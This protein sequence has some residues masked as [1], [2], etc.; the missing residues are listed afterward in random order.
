MNNLRGLYAITDNRLTPA[1]SILE[2]VKEALAG[3]ARI[4]QLRDKFSSDDQLIDLAKELRRLCHR[5]GAIFLINDRVELARLVKADGVHLGKDDAA[6]EEA[7]QVLGKEVIIG[8]SCYNEFERA[9]A[10]AEA[11]ADYVA[12]G[13]FFPS[14]TKPDAVRAN[15]ELLKKAKANINVPIC[16]IG[17]ITSSNA[18]ELIEAGADMIAVISDLWKAPDVRLKAKQFSSIFGP[19]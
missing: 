8:I 14:P 7:R 2:M 6:Y 1:G 17:G 4:I 3:G 9:I 12:F 16:A 5:Y 15:K 10:A 19:L 18:A 11:G 13:S